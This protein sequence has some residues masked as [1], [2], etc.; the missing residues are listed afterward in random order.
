ML[1]ITG[2]N[3]AT[4]LAQTKVYIGHVLNWFCTIENITETEVR[5]RTP[6]I[7]KSYLPGVA[8]SVVME[9]RLV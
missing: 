8:V 4:D 6:V 5:C 9:T 7:S 2:K 3:F 1:T